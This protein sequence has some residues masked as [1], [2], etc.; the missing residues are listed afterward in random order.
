MKRVK[1]NTLYYDRAT[2]QQILGMVDT[3]TEKTFNLLEK[4]ERNK[5]FCVALV[6]SQHDGSRVGI[7][8]TVLFPPPTPPTPI[9][10]P[11]FSFSLLSPLLCVF[12]K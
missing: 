11:F 8:I 2:S 1:L 6:E 7:L 3:H 4:D 5:A 10:I 9:F 12:R